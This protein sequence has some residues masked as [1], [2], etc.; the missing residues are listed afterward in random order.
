MQVRKE[1]L[2]KKD[3]I[4]KDLRKTIE[5]YKTHVRRIDEEKYKLLEAKDHKINDLSSKNNELL[6]EKEEQQNK[7]KLLL[8]PKY[9]NKDLVN[10]IYKA[11]NIHIAEKDWS[12]DDI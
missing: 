10:S 2:E 9:C 5:E 6:V 3:R 1:D 12:F 7:I 8:N 4:I 11:L